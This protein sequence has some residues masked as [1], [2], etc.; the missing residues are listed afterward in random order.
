MWVLMLLLLLPMAQQSDAAECRNRVAQRSGATE[1]II[2]SNIQLFWVDLQSALDQLP[3][4]RAL[5]I[6]VTTDVGVGWA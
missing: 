3:L 2:G 4:V 6:R 5:W 1:W